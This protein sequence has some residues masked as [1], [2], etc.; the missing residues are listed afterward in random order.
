MRSRA[1]A[2]AAKSEARATLSSASGPGNSRRVERLHRELDQKLVGRVDGARRRALDALPL[3]GMDAD[4][5]VQ[6]SV[7]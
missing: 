2:C 5:L 3:F 4:V 1:R 6:G 7:G